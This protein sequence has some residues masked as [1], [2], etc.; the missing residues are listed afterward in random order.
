LI[1]DYYGIEL[2]EKEKQWFAGDG[3]ELKGSI[4]KG[5]D[6]MRCTDTRT[7]RTFA[8]CR[9]LT[10]KLLQKNEMK[11]KCALMDDFADD[12]DQCIQWLKKI[13]FLQN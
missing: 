3:K 1:F 6:K 2:S 12:F 9:T 5:E 4:L 7:A 11:N 13:N 8:S 10:V